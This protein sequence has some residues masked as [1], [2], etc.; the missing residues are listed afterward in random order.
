MFYYQYIF[1]CQNY[2]LLL[3]WVDFCLTY[4]KTLARTARVPEKDVGW[5]YSLRL[6]MRKLTYYLLPITFYLLLI[7][8]L[9]SKSNA[10]TNQFILL[11]CHSHVLASKSSSRSDI[12]DRCPSEYCP[13][14]R[15]IDILLH[16][17]LSAQHDLCH[18]LHQE[19]GV[20]SPN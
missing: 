6:A 13:P 2:I 8:R 15:I 12:V 16:S 20:G 14:T 17:N 18:G 19:K 7:S 1:S 9:Y 11:L 4:S 3:F 10:S 5:Q